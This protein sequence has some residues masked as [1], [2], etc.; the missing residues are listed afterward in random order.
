MNF[1]LHS[2]NVCGKT[3]DSNIH[4]KGPIDTI[5]FSVED[6]SSVFISFKNVNECLPNAIFVRSIRLCAK[7]LLDYHPLRQFLLTVVFEL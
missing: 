4:F 2:G 5:H 7:I 3:N 6:C 1:T